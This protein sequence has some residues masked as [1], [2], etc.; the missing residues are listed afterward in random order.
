MMWWVG[1]ILWCGQ[2]IQ[3]IKGQCFYVVTVIYVNHGRTKQSADLTSRRM[4]V[5]W[6][7]SERRTSSMATVNT[8]RDP[9]CGHAVSLIPKEQHA[10]RMRSRWQHQPL[11]LSAAFMPN[12]WFNTLCFVLSHQQRSL[13][14]E[15]LPFWQLPVAQAN[16][17][18]VSSPSSPKSGTDLTP[19]SLIIWVKTL[20]FA[21]ELGTCLGWN[22]ILASTQTKHLMMQTI[23]VWSTKSG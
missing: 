19:L 10:T 16:Y 22:R 13:T 17:I 8:F 6:K 14:N 11:L 4:S 9:A 3:Y 2:Q 1:A 21:D 18:L 5:P 15:V 12:T 20:C 23:M 7:V